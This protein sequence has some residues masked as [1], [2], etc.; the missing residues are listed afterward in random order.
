V[1]PWVHN[2]RGCCLAYQCQLRHA[3]ICVG[4]ACQVNHI[5]QPEDDGGSDLATCEPCACGAMRG[6]RA[7]RGCWPSGALPDD[8]EATGNELQPD[9]T[10]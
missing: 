2:Q 1:S 5:V 10:W 9:R 3:D 7:D 8:L 4:R 6:A